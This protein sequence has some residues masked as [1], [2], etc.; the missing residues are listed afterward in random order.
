VKR[1]KARFKRLTT[2]LPFQ[3]V[4]NPKV[5]AHSCGYLDLTDCQ[6]LSK[7]ALYL[8]DVTQT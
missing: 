8:C 2:L 4:T 7:G 6:V 5:V 1:N 3:D